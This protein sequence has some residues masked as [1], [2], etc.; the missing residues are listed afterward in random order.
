MLRDIVP[1]RRLSR[2]EALK[3]AEAQAN[4]LLRLSSVTEPPVGEDIIAVLPN[5]Q[6][7]RVEPAQAQAAA[8]WSNGRWL[9]LLNGAMSLG[10]QRFSL[11]HEFKHILDHPFVSILY[12]SRDECV[13]EQACDYFAACLL[14][15]RRWLR[16]A[17]AEG[18][19]DVPTLARRFGVSPL[20]VKIRL[21][22]IGLI[23]PT[24]HYL[25]K[26]A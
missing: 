10:R 14:M 6:I 21:L 19:R 20:A 7:E 17:W 26:E 3:V 22:Q 1:L 9:V 2:P 23:Q 5:I 12:W 24:S 13:T 18:I 4:R 15:P 8:E 11:A 16:Q 25:A